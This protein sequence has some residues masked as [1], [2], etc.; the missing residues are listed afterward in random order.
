M[1][2]LIDI[3]NIHII[4][5]WVEDS[6]EYFDKREDITLKIL[7]RNIIFDRWLRKY[8][9]YK[10]DTNVSQG[11]WIEN[12]KKRLGNIIFFRDN[13]CSCSKENNCIHME[14]KNICDLLAVKKTGE[15]GIGIQIFM[16]L[17]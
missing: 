3:Q 4:R 8:L 2:V 13:T 5:E 15:I 1:S 6:D 7:Y 17:Y 16:F 12:K 11:W 9:E 14:T 10:H